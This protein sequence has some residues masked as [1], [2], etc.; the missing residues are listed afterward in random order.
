MTKLEK[1]QQQKAD[2]K[3]RA[4]A[5][6]ALGTETTPLTAEQKA[7]ID[8]LLAQCK[9]LDAD[10]VREQAL[11]ELDRTAPAASSISVGKDNNEDKPWE[12]FGHMLQAVRK[13]ATSQGREF[14]PRL[15]AALGANE[16]IPAEG[17]FLV[18]PEYASGIL[19]RTYEVGQVTSRCR[20]IPMSS[21]RLILN[22]LDEDARTTGQRFGGIQVFRIAEAATYTGSKPKF[23]QIELN[24]NKLIGLFYG[25]EE[26]LADTAALEAWVNDNFPL[27]FGFQL[28][29][30]AVSG[31][32]A[33]QMLGVLSSQTLVTVAA[34]SG[35]ATATIV[36]N[37]I[38]NMW[39]RLYAPS[40]RNAVWYIN[41]D[42]EAQLYTLT[43]GTGTAVELLYTPPGMRG[44]NNDYGLLLGRPVIPIE[45][46]ST[47][48]TV[49]DLIL[50]DMDQYIIGE[51]SGIRADSSI[52]VQFLTG[53]DTFRWMLRNDGQPIWKKALTPYKGAN[54]LSPFVT[55][56]TRP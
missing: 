23:R 21:N 5:I 26:I 32:G 45:Q 36:T 29:T 31:N 39:K 50:A 40:R 1:L 24:A 48:G 18:S 13:H 51:R 14:D 8:G 49:G 19:E 11:L 38:L 15:R 4:E 20:K 37:N 42:T 10:I 22:G 54:T 52:H 34:E 16:S 6:N 35:Q 28:D 44:N 12:S 47:L 30:E 3:K 27:A 53:E 55:L 41:Q 9:Q 7:E 17:G 46:C 33:G 43:L 56:A 25:T 2:A